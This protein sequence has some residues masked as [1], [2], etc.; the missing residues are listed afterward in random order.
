[1]VIAGVD[2]GGK[3]EYLAG[4]YEGVEEKGCKTGSDGNLRCS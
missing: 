4:I 1:V 3:L 2:E